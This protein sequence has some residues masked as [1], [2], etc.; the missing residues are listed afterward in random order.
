MS[1][2]QI[3]ALIPQLQEWE[4][5]L[6]DAKEQVESL[7]DQIK[8]EMVNRQVE[9]LDTETGYIV[10]YT[11]VISNRFDSTNFK[12]QHKELYTEFCKPTTTHRFTVSK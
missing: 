8:Q 12:K 1:T 7:K 5:L 2:I 9:E 11:T 3:S 6:A 10:R 4:S